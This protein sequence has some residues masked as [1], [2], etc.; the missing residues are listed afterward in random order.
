MSVVGKN[1]LKAMGKPKPSAPSGLHLDDAPFS[2]AWNLLAKEI[3]AGWFSNGF[4]YLFGEGLEALR[5]CLDAWSFLLPAAKQRTIIGRNG[6]GA[7][8]VVEN[9]ADPQDGRVCI[10]DPVTV[11]YWSNPNCIFINFIGAWLPQKKVPKEFVDDALYRKWVAKNKATPELTDIVAWKTPASLG[12]KA[13][14]D[15]VQL[16]NI[17]EYYQ[18]T[19]PTYAKAFANLRNKR[20]Q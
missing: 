17:V 6:Y 15:N 1:F 11:Q 9:H 10:L 14:L 19:A 7:I 18:S 16:E 3:G 20:K 12:G 8:A 2:G 13:T 4:L 5:P